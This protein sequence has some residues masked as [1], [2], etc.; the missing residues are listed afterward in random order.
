MMNNSK[1]NNFN[2]IILVII[3]ALSLWFLAGC[4]REGSI[5]NRE[6]ETPGS[7]TIPFASPQAVRSPTPANT[8]SYLVPM[9]NLRELQVVFWH[10]WV[11]EMAE[12]VDYLVDRF[13][14]T[15]EWGIHIIAQGMGSS[16]A[17][18]DRLES[19]LDEGGTPQIVVAPSET[20]HSW[21][22][23][24]GIILTLDDFVMDA[25]YGMVTTGQS[26][27]FPASAWWQDQSNGIQIAIPAQR[28]LRVMLYN[29][30]WAKELGFD[31]PPDSLKTWREQ[32]CAAAKALAT[33]SIGAND[34]TGGWLVNTNGVTVYAWLRVFDLQNAY[35]PQNHSFSFEQTESNQA[36][37]FLKEMVD[38]GCAW[39][40]RN[41]LPYEYFA[42]RNALFISIDL[43]DLEAQVETNKRLGVADEWLILP[44]PGTE[45]PVTII[46]GLSYGILESNPQKEL[47]SWLFVRWMSLPDAQA[48]LLLA[49]GGVPLSPGAMEIAGEALPAYSLWETALSFV[50]LTEPP[51]ITGAWQEARYILGDAAWYALQSNVS[52]ERIPEILGELDATISEVLEY[53][54]Y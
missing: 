41:P 36:F 17:L 44:Y 40:G 27:G 48:R 43:S 54:G 29:H 2:R 32:A 53:K 37:T 6:K 22:E 4:Q 13:N 14:Q 7:P 39:I 51:P 47:A 34:G 1:R 52:I 46:S 33:D 26:A 35:D 23:R 25:A 45:K 50:P 15:N 21:Y 20:L 18:A 28:G 8:P 5:G 38:E 11:G 30:T 24:D 49:G 3:L 10:P 19:A 12:E 9:E 42:S 16:M 31:N